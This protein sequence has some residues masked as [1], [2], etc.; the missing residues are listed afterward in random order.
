[1]NKLSKKVDFSILVA[2]ASTQDGARIMAV[3]ESFERQ[4]GDFSTEIILVDRLGGAINEE[5]RRRF[6]C[7]RVM[8]CGATEEIPAMRA[9]AL[10]LS[11]G[12]YV[13]VTED[14]CIA[15]VNWLQSFDDTIRRL[16]RVDIV[17]GSVSNGVYETKLDWATFLCEYASLVPPIFTGFNSSIAGMNVAYRRAIFANVDEDKLTKGFWETTL[18]PEFARAGF[19][20][21]SDNAIQIEH[22]K[23]FD[24][25]FFVKQRF[26]YSR[27]FAGT[28]YEREER[29]KRFVFTLATPVLP[30]IL[31][32]R[33]LLISYEKK[34]IRSYVFGAAFYLVIFF[35]V[36]AAGEAVGYVLGPGRALEKIE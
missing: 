28:R 19:T 23:R 27:Y 11:S 13:I 12:T 26:M 4:I 14:H 1:M 25:G 5:I 6:P 30:M 24:F 3:L 31:L 16:G 32:F 2:R 20:M 17:G 35:L 8:N 21:I 29:F 33:L 7:V 18:H 10:S 15:P 36:W 34:A 9:R 22:C